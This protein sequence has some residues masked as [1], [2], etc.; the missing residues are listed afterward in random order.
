MIP[1][2]FALEMA[3]VMDYSIMKKTV[4]MAA[5][6]VGS[7]Y[8]CL[9][10]VIARASLGISQNECPIISI[11]IIGVPKKIFFTYLTQFFLFFKEVSL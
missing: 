10:G 3:I 4:M 11:L 1:K 6:V 7:M 5:I 9:H 2:I 8:I